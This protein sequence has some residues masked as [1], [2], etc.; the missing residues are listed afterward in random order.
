M[1]YEFEK[2]DCTGGSYTPK[3]SVRGNGS[4]GFSQGALRRFGLWDGD[5][6]VQ[7]YFDRKNQVI[8][9]EPSNT[10][11]TGRA[12][13]VKKKIQGKDGRQ[14]VNAYVA[15]KSF[16]DFYGI[17]YSETKSY[18]A[19]RDDDTKMI[20]FQL[21]RPDPAPTPVTVQKEGGAPT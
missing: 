2:F 18:L 5:W 7:L 11:G 21:A 1:R 12:H 15:A 10:P 20:V 6:F 13:L 4:L 3:I 14:S 9:I 19:K 8:G 16:F 17:D